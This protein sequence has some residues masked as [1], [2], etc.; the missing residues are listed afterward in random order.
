LFIVGIVHHMFIWQRRPRVNLPFDGA[1]LACGLSLAD[2]LHRS[3]R[4]GGVGSKQA[5]G[6]VYRS[7]VPCVQRKQCSRKNLDRRIRWVAALAF[8][9]FLVDFRDYC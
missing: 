7:S 6:R 2:A 8:P 3:G 5:S 1:C 4:H 9:N